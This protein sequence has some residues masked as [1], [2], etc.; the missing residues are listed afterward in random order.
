MSHNQQNNAINC[1]FVNLHLPV[2]TWL[3]SSLKLTFS[4]QNCYQKFSPPTACLG[5]CPWGKESEKVTCPKGKSTCPGGLDGVFFEPC[6]CMA[7]GWFALYFE[8][9]E[10]KIL[11]HVQWMPRG[12]TTRIFFFFCCSFQKNSGTFEEKT[13]SSEK[14]SLTSVLHQAIHSNILSHFAVL[15]WFSR[16]QIFATLQNINN[17]NFSFNHMHW[18]QNSYKLTCKSSWVQ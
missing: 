15:R 13:I 12:G 6:S 7:F 3:P 14:D 16:I 8:Q 2:N 9:N 1:N 5:P 18:K 10:D 17:W 11:K 4:S